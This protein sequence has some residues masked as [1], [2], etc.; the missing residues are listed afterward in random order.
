MGL[1]ISVG[2]LAEL[3]EDDPEGAAWFETGLSAANKLL[4]QAG[5]PA[6]VEPRS[7]ELSQSRAS[8]ESFPYSFIHYL[9]R[10]YAH[11]CAN[12]SWVASAL[13]EDEDPINDPVL[14]AEGD[15]LRSHLL[16]HSD[17]EGFYLPVDFNEVLFAD[18][19]CGLPGGM[20]GSSY[21]LLDELI[22]AAPALG[23][24]LDAGQLSDD[25][26]ARIDELACSGEGMF[27]EYCSW[28]ALYEAARI[29]IEYKTAVV[30][31]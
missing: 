19:D 8:I 1:A 26:A 22:V 14:E 20:L 5:L 29:S 10:A 27:R 11:R 21:R 3:L 13:S 12:P 9:R 7:L 24:R 18:E 25:E 23:I 15:M 28:L 2:M 17:A 4:V 16:C 6:H 31:C 30:F